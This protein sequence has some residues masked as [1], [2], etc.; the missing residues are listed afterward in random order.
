MSRVDLA[1]VLVRSL[2]CS[3]SSPRIHS[4]GPRS[5]GFLRICL[6]SSRAVHMLSAVQMVFLFAD[7]SFLGFLEWYQFGPRG[8]FAYAFFSAHF[9]Y[10][11]I[12]EPALP[13]IVVC[14]TA[15]CACI[16]LTRCVMVYVF[17]CCFAMYFICRSAI[18]RSDPRRDICVP[19]SNK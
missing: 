3:V 5:C 18:K 8:I 10:E 4:A 11:S 9:A 13:R 19:S 7:C 12:A 1:I 17:L 2:M 6:T 14:F 16:C 15:I